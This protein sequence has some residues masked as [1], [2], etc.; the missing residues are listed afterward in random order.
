MTWVN[1]VVQGVLLGGYYAL[2]ACGL[3]L[4]FGVMRI[5]NLAHGDIAVLGAYLILVVPRPLGRLGVRRA[6][7]GAAGDADPR[8]TA[9]SGSMLDRALRSGVLV[10]LL[11]TFGL[12]IVIQNLLLEKFSPDVRSLGGNAGGVVTASWQISNELSISAL[13]ALILGVAVGD[14][15]RAAA[16][17]LA[18]QVGPA[19]ARDRA[20]PR[21]RGARRDRLAR[22]C[23]RGRPRSRSRR[24]RSPACSSRC[25]RPSTRSRARRS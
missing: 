1:A 20:G 23:T 11:A 3:S 4:M 17:P 12:S 13:G 6:H 16:L 9:C 24:R 15:R 8:A 5:I 10:P 7:A 22:R 19:D 18:H 21:H 14:P 2:L 25:A